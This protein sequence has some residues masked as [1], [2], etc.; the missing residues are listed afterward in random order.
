[1]PG[2][3]IRSLCGEP[4]IAWT[5]REAKRSK[6]LDEVL[7]STDC[8]RTAGIS[9]TY[10]ATVPFLRPE[11]LA[12]DTA[13][14]MEVILHALDYLQR[15]GQWYDLLMYLQPT[16]PLRTAED[17]DVATE[18][19]LSSNAKAIVSVSEAD[20]NPN[21]VN[22]LPSD[23][24]MKNFLK[25]EFANT[26]RQDHQVYYRINGAIYLAFSQYLKSHKTFFGNETY[27][28]VMSR[29]RSIDIDNEIDFK[30]AEIMLSIERRGYESSPCGI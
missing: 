8:E 14:A 4:L 26:N 16:S 5:I 28:Y 6:Y 29:D 24:C 27:A 21:T 25:P 12:T 1:M 13:K 15:R 19:L 11:R 3:N 9:R 22:I 2:K 20:M 10:G 18:V 17:I 23:R 30:F 7:V